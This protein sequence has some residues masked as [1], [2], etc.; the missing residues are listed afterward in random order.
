MLKYEQGY[1]MCDI[2][3]TDR[4]IMIS[5]V[6]TSSCLPKGVGFESQGSRE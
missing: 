2:T 3:K 5:L 4:S 6:L 1:K